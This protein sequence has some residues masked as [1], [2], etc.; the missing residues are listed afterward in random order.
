MLRKNQ[1]N[2]VSVKLRLLGN[3]VKIFNIWFYHLRDNLV[4]VISLLPYTLSSLVM[5]WISHWG[6]EMPVARNRLAHPFLT[7]L[8]LKSKE[9]HN[10]SW[11]WA[12]WYQYQ[13]H[14]SILAHNTCIPQSLFMYYSVICWVNITSE[15]Y[16]YILPN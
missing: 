9:V 16:K 10:S 15:I 14:R 5:L 2:G 4:V 12:H 7:M 11:L 8:L 13:G 1:I 3:L 6:Y